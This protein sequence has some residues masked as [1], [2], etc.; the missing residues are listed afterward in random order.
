MTAGALSAGDRSGRA[1]NEHA[2]LCSRRRAG[3]GR[4][5]AEPL[6]QRLEIQNEIGQQSRRLII[7]SER[8]QQISDTERQLTRSP[9]NSCSQC[10]RIESQKPKQPA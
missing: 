3:C 9:A 8:A 2:E 6:A 5:A 10:V 7:A 1:R 4:L